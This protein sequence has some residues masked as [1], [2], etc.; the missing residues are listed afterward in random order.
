MTMQDDCPLASAMADADDWRAVAAR[1][2]LSGKGVEDMLRAL[3]PDL[4]PRWLE[5]RKSE[6]VRPCHRALPEMRELVAEAV[7]DAPLD[8]SATVNRNLALLLLAMFAVTG[9]I[10]WP[11]GWIR[12][13]QE[14]FLRAGCSVPTPASIR[15]LRGRLQDDPAS[16]EGLPGADTELLR[17]L[18]DRSYGRAAA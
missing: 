8:P 13:V 15:W 6:L 3:R 2:E 4:L 5:L 1:L 10:R 12:A 18:E 16:F 9:S 7:A 14:E 17:D 11:G